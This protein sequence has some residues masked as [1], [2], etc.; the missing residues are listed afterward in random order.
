MRLPAGVL[1]AL[2][3]GRLCAAQ[4]PVES[5]ANNAR[6]SDDTIAA[7]KLVPPQDS[8][9]PL[10]PA[11]KF[12]YHIVRTFDP[13]ALVRT[14][15]STAIDWATDSP[16][17]W[18]AGIDGLGIRFSSKIGHRLTRH[19]IMAG[20]QSVIRDDPRRIPTTATAFLPRARQ[21]VLNTYRVTH[22]DGVHYRFDYS[23]VIAAYGAAFVSRTWHPPGYRSSGDALVNGTMTLGID[24]A[25]SLVWEFWPVVK[26]KVFRGR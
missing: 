11:K 10:S 12:R 16:E 18:P 22:D 13:G 3:F 6:S 21:A 20:V 26:N 23:R 7:I 24:A 25:M 17:P 19:V 8:Y 4:Q 9:Q 2:A 1:C 5:P 15:F 14:G